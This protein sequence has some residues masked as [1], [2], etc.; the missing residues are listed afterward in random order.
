MYGQTGVWVE[1]LSERAVEGDWKFAKIENEEE[2][3]TDVEEGARRGRDTE[4]ANWVLRLS[5][6]VIAYH[7]LDGF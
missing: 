3:E 7:Y 4:K 6:F 2:G 1:V 5:L